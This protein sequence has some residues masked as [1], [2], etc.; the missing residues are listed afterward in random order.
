MRGST[1]YSLVASSAALLLLSSPFISTVTASEVDGSVVVLNSENFGSITQNNVTLVK[2]YAPWCGHCKNL[3]PEYEKAA[4]RLKDYVTL[5]EVDCTVE[6]SICRDVGIKGYPTLKIYRK[7]D[8][9]VEASAENT[10]IKDYNGPRQEDGIVSYMKKE[11]LPDVTILQPENVEEFSTSD[12]VVTIGKFTSIDSDEY[13][14]FVKAASKLRDSVVFG[15]VIDENLESAQITVHKT[16]DEGKNDYEHTDFS[17]EAIGAFVEVSSI[18]IMDELSPENYQ[19]YIES[20][21]PLGYYFYSSTEEY[22]LGNKVVKEVAKLHRGKINFVFLD[23]N[24]FGGH[25]SVVNLKQEWPAFAIHIAQ[26]NRKF[27]YELAKF[28]F[29]QLKSFVQDFVEGK[30][31][32]SLKSEAIPESNSEPVKVIVGKTFDEIVNDKTK[33]VFLEIYAPWC[34][35]CKRLAPIWEELA[36]KLAA[37]D[38]IVIAKMDG[39]E[40]D[41]PVGTNIDI[42]GFP[43]LKLIKAETNEIIDYQ[44]DRSL[45][46]LYSFIEKNSKFINVE[47]R[48]EL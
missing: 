31:E 43:T 2:F 10:L 20:G 22:D 37:N 40:N 26:T 18:P 14:A 24:K 8:E 15:A 17:E 6:E 48:E 19:R 4:A 28:E 47:T 3:A 27:P 35:H 46:D 34:G 9:E 16:F 42:Q 30:I 23:A 11:I 25:A 5:A 1:I 39:T 13:K 32:P 7:K 45:E 36:T 12:K 44:G 33:D 29:E 38:N 21:V 41:I